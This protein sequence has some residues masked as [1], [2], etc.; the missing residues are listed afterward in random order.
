MAVPDPND[1]KIRDNGQSPGA[2]VS[3]PF[4]TATEERFRETIPRVRW[5]DRLFAGQ[6]PGREGKTPCSVWLARELTE[7]IRPHRGTRPRSSF[8]RVDHQ[9]LSG[10]RR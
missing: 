1:I 3:F 10:C 8:V 7:R 2:I 6:S 5:N 9:P 4:D